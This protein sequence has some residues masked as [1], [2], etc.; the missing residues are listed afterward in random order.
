MHT[1][2]NGNRQ[3]RH[4]RFCKLIVIEDWY[5][6]EKYCKKWNDNAEVMAEN[7]S[8]ILYYRGEIIFFSFLYERKNSL[9]LVLNFTMIFHL[10][11]IYSGR[12]YWT[13]SKKYISIYYY[14]FDLIQILLKNCKIHLFHL[15]QR[16]KRI[17][18]FPSDLIIYSNPIPRDSS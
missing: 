8:W 15:W 5:R 13:W 7:S 10:W 4:S 17:T 6:Q 9:I 18:F 12:F 11:F 1:L 2:D 3:V 14:F 16:Q